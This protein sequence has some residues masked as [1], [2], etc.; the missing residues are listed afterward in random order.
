MIADLFFKASKAERVAKAL[1][2]DGEFDDAVSR[3]YYA[4]YNAARCLLICENPSNAEVSSHK[5]VLSNFHRQLIHSGKVEK[6]FGAMIQ[7]AQ[8]SR[9]V[10]DYD[11][12][13]LSE[14]N[15]QE[16]VENAERFLAMARGLIPQ[17]DLPPPLG[18][19][20][21]DLRLEAAKE[22][23]G[24]LAAVQMLA[25]VVRGLGAEMDRRLA[26]DLVLYGTETSIATMIELLAARRETPAELRRLA[27]NVGVELPE[28]TV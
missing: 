15:A 26:E 16:H 23:A 21:R 20:P 22:E 27:R 3:A 1:L 12:E 7:R 11:Q 18:Q 10:A 13:P 5:G 17:S 6:Q 28:H 14:R 19:S 8:T 2:E 24:K 9:H 4:M 25:A